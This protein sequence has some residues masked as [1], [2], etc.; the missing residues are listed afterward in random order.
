MAT[1]DL[2]VD[3]SQAL[4][5]RIRLRERHA[6]VSPAAAG[7]AVLFV[8]GAT[9]PGAMFDVPGTSWLAQA[10][11]EG[12][13]AYAL[14]VRGYGGSTRPAVM[15]GPPER[16]AP[17]A[18]AEAAIADI[19]DC[20]AT[21]RERAD[22][23][24]VDVVGWSWGT[25]TCGG[26]AASSPGTIGRLV[27]FAPVYCHADP[28]RRRALLGR[29]G[30]ADPDA[31]GAYRRV[32]MAQ[33]ATRWDADFDG[34]EPARWRASGV[35][36]DWFDLMCADEPADVVRAPNGVLL[37]LSEALAGGARYDAAAI[38]VPTLVVRG[39]ADATAV[40]A[41][42]LGLYDT[43]G[44]AHRQYAEIAGGGHFLLLE[45]RAP[46]LFETVSRFF[47]GPLDDSDAGRV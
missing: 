5:E 14:D 38:D 4:G 3:S 8:H 44:S 35:L 33:A 22:V 15:A 47:R 28:G 32:T 17:F 9:Y 27:L 25:M 37:D 19:A 10:A 43:L 2:Y 1:T 7:R 23:A 11:A 13:A 21:I 6:G 46:A 36:E 16:G 26:Y 18:R 24:T 41:D 30:A 29:R 40:R 12:Y 20:I 34:G 42:A 31:L 45:R 39:S